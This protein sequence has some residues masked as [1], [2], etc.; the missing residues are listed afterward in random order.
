MAMTDAAVRDGGKLHIMLA[1]VG[2]AYPTQAML[3]RFDADS[4]SGNEVQAVTVSGATGGTF[5]LTFDGQTTAA[6]AFDASAATVQTEL[7]ALTNIDSGDVEATGGPLNTAAVNVEFRGQYAGVNVALMTA[8][9]SLTGTGATV[10]V[11][12]AEESWAPWENI[13]HTDLEEDVETD[14]EGGDS[15]VRGSRQNPN[16]RERVE[17]VTQYLTLN[18]IQVTTQTLGYY[19]GS[20]TATA[21]VYSTDGT[22]PATERAVL[23]VF[24]DGEDIS[25]VHYPKA[26]LRRAGAPAMA[27]A[28]FR[29][30]PIRITPLKRTGEPLQRWIDPA[31]VA[32]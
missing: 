7:E 19:F 4:G 8:T 10:D 17:P 18:S 16:L 11:T 20:G 9:S 31:I 2:T 15:E 29:R 24:V 26:N 3:D 23:L 21:G 14:E 30:L 32:A 27:G 13:G 1:P 6:I 22:F 28:G 25:G 5:T 12:V